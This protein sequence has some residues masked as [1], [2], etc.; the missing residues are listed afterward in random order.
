MVLDLACRQRDLAG[1]FEMRHRYNIRGYWINEVLKAVVHD[2]FVRF[3]RAR[4]GVDGY[5]G[6]IVDYSA[7]AMRAAAL[8][9]LGRA[10]I[11]CGKGWVEECSGGL[12]WDIL[13]ETYGVGWALEAGN[14]VIIRKGKIKAPI[15]ASSHPEAQGAK[16][17]TS[18]AKPREVVAT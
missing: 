1:A 9:T 17:D 5:Q 12:G 14:K 7:N 15:Q 10:Y 3:W 11:G 2:D 4:R 13:K 6:K 18:R 8:K 16:A